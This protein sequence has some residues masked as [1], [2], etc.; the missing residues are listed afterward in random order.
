MEP[1]VNHASWPRLSKDG[2]QLVFVS[3]ESANGPNADGTDARSV[4]LLGSN[5]MNSIIDAPLFLP[6]GQTILFSKIK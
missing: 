6:D 2:S 1:V 4:S 5:W 3:T